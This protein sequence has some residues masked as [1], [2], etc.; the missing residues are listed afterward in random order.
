LPEHLL[1]GEPHDKLRES[2]FAQRPIGSGRFRFSRREAGASLELVADTA[3]YRGR[4]K[5]DR[6]IWTVVSDPTTLGTHIATEQAD[7]VEVL[8]GPAIDQVSSSS[9]ARVMPYATLDYGFAEFNLHTGGARGRSHPLFADLGLRR[10]LAL[11]VDRAGIVRNVLDSLGYVGIG[12]VVRAQA[13]SDPSLALPPFDT[14]ASTALL[15]SLGWR[16]RNEDGLRERGSV[17]LAFTLMT[18]ASS[19]V[20][21]SMAVLLQEQWRRVGAK[22]TLELVEPNLFFERLTKGQFDVVLNAWHA[23]P[24][25]SSARQL[26]GSGQTPD[27]GGSNHVGYANPVFDAY[28]DSA[29]AQFDPQASRAYYRKAYERLAADAPA[30][31]LYEAR[32]AAGVH[33]RLKLT[34]VRADAWW[35]GLPEWSVTPALRIARDRVPLGPTATAAAPAPP[36]RV[37]ASAQP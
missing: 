28:L 4:P 2:A 1:G 14:A 29:A 17:P 16:D 10:A 8:R 25:P 12:P 23:D 32:Y 13:T 24:S 30:I 22:V 6:V 19:S 33:K 27:R 35:A 18:P 36:R 21:R 9:V 26:W 31:W 5:L 11:A 3:N 20:R 15:D 7:F 37:A 34:G